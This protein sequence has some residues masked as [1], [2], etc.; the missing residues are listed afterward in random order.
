MSTRMDLR[1]MGHVLLLGLL[2]AATTLLTT[3]RAEKPAPPP[4]QPAGVK[5]KGEKGGPEQGRTIRTIVKAVDVGKS[6]ITIPDKAKGKLGKQVLELADDVKVFLRLNKGKGPQPEGKLT[7]VREGVPVSLELSAD[8][9]TVVRITVSG[10]RISASVRSVDADKRT[11][12]VLSKGGKVKG[13]TEET[14]PLSKD[15]RVVVPNTRK[16]GEFELRQLADLTEGTPVGLTFSPRDVGTVAGITVHGRSLGGL[17][18]AVDPDNDT[19][20]LK[21]GDEERTLDVAKDAYIAIQGDPKGTKSKLSELKAGMRVK[22]SLSALDQEVVN[23]WVGSRSMNAIVKS[24]DADK[25]TITVTSKGGKG[26]GLTE[27]TFSLA[28]DAR[29]GVPSGKKKGEW[30]LRKLADLTEGTPVGLT[31]SAR[32]AEKIAAITVYGR[33]LGAVVEAV[34]PDKST[35]TIRTGD[36]EQTLDV[37]DDVRIVIHEGKVRLSARDGSKLVADDLRI[38]FDKGKGQLSHLKTGMK[39]SLG[40]S[41]LD[42]KTVVTIRLHRGTG[43]VKGKG[44]GEGKIKGEGKFKDKGEFKGK[45]VK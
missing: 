28:D 16:K 23:I 35:I 12:T 10:R 5:I 24:V 41:A 7:D 15:A 25:G 9:D 30:E 20:V 31:F 14:F 44:K 22:L 45:G 21:I 11:I 17:L 34:D 40:L 39:V 33:N 37:A 2:I 4:D 6:T 29:I 27:E 36:E 8:G 1:G 43:P 38:V 13:G 42:Q 18:E 32:D 3:V 26:K 19:L